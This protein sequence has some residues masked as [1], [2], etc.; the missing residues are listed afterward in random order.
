MKKGK[1]SKQRGLTIR[2]KIFWGTAGISISLVLLVTFFAMKTTYDS[3]YSQVIS[4]REMSIGWLEE[5]LNLSLKEYSDQFYTLEVDKQTKADILSWCKPSGELDYAARW[6]LITATNAIISMDANINSIELYNLQ[7]N[8]VLTAR[9]SGASLSDT[10]GRLALWQSRDPLLQNNMVLMREDS[11]ILVMHQINRFETN[12]PLALAVIRLKPAAFVDIMNNI[13]SS[14]EE[15]LLMLNDAGSI[16]ATA[17]NGSNALNESDI[18]KLTTALNPSGNSETAYDGNYLFS[19]QV[20]RGK[21]RILQ[22]VPGSVITSPLRQTL[23]VGLL[24]AVFGLLGALGLALLFTRI[25]SRPIIQ[26]AEKMQHVTIR[27]YNAKE[28]AGPRTDEIGLLEDSFHVMIIRN[29]ELIAQ[30]FQTKIEK[31][32]AQLRA[33]QAQINPHFLY[34]TLQSIGGMA[35]KKNA[36]EIYGVTLDLSDILRYSLSFS[37]EMVPLKEEVK[38][39]DSYLSIQNKRFSDRIMLH[40]EIEEECQQVLIPKLILQPMVENSLEHGLCEKPGAWELSLCAQMVN[41]TDMRLSLTDN[42]L[43]MS[44]ERLAYIRDELQKGADNAIAAGAHIGLNNVNTRIRLK[45]GAPYGVTIESS[46]GGGTTVT[47]LVRALKEEENWPTVL[48]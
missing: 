7:N 30:K 19:R 26:L 8:T 37:K 15:S 4:L 41:D 23:L 12:T 2:Q 39:L 47:I 38:Y 33:L 40:R 24:A 9:R 44:L 5:R 10:G 6:R 25:I 13:R 16:V 43:G 17:D 20:S 32:S 21:L 35:L 3:L 28:T 42:G 36:P 18:A 48:S 27:E 46:P 1:S 31:R 11:E 29:Q 45:F 22:L 34:N 14:S